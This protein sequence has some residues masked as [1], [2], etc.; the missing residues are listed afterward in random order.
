MNHQPTDLQPTD[1]QV[2]AH[3]ERL[4]KSDGLPRLPDKNLSVTLLRRLL[5][6]RGVEVGK[7][8]LS[9][10]IDELGVSR[11]RHRAI[12]LDDFTERARSGAFTQFIHQQHALE[13][14]VPALVD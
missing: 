10:L 3:L 11:G 12:D 6:Y 1:V 14:Q 8:R 9:G 7:N 13:A 4:V 5:A 2:V